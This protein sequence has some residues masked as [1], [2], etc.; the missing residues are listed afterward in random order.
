MI[1]SCDADGKV[2]VQ[3]IQ[4]VAFGYY[5]VEKI[6]VVDVTKG[7]QART[8]ILASRFFDKQYPKDELNDSLSM[9]AI[10]SIDE[11]L[12]QVIED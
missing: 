5:T 1:C 8:Q 10:G 4:S 11:V 6:G 9:I 3:R 7:L 12:V 2:L